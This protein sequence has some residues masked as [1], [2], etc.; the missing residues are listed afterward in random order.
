MTG[1]ALQVV[2]GDAPGDLITLVPR[3]VVAAILLAVAYVVADRVGDGAEWLAER[4]DLGDA[5]LETP[6]GVVFEDA[7]EVGDVVEVVAR[8]AVLLVG[9]VVA[10]SMAGF[11]R[12]SEIA[13]AVVRYAPSVFGAVAVVLVGFVVAGYVGRSVK[14]S[15]VVG[16]H[17]FTPVVA[18][19]VQT[20]IYF[21][22]VTL[23]LDALGYSTTI[24]NTLAQAVALGL[25]LGLALAIGI[26]LGLGSQDY[27]AE[28]VDDWLGE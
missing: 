1:A 8:Y 27:V 25:G 16:G 24:L 28:N 13:F 12:V 2:P 3:L 5:V 17:A 15:D 20:V 22:V 26:G 21:V 18:T 6:L 4:M 14:A 11:N 23:A 19:T 9:V 10:A 7:D